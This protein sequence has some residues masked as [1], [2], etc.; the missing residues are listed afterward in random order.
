M[1]V[2]VALKVYTHFYP[3]QFGDELLLISLQYHTLLARRCTIHL[4]LLEDF[5]WNITMRRLRQGNV[6]KPPFLSDGN[7][8]LVDKRETGRGVSHQRGCGKMLPQAPLISYCVFWQ[9]NEDVGGRK[10][11]HIL[12]GNC[13]CVCVLAELYQR[14]FGILECNL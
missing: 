7:R 2:R 6:S 14:E 4:P 5:S 8:L 1:G 12:C 10:Y 13:I 11:W 3:P 9:L